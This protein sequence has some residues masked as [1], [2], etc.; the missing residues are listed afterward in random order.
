MEGLVRYLESVT[1]HFSRGQPVEKDRMENIIIK[2]KNNILKSSKKCQ[3]V[4]KTLTGSLITTVK[5][6][7]AHY[8]TLWGIIS[9][10]K[11]K[12]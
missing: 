1:T 2:M 5:L 11:K 9:M 4:R 10:C 12:F 8:K 3:G 6:S 7:V